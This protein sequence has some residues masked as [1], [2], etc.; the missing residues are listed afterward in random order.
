MKKFKILL[1]LII[2]CL[3]GL[4]I[5]QNL[6]YFMT[7]QTVGVHFRDFQWTSMPFPVL[8][9]W[10]ICFVAGLLISEVRG[11]AKS[12]GLGR[13]LKKKNLAIKEMEIQISELQTRINDLT[14]TPVPPVA[15]ASASTPAPVSNESQPTE[16]TNSSDGEMKKD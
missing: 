5:Y 11:F 4:F 10:G 13:E 12:F 2:L 9:Y 7:K 6:E 14:R 1:L 8:F 16:I 15:A 3:L